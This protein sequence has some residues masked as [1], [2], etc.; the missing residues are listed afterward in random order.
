MLIITGA[1]ANCYIYS[2]VVNDYCAGLACSA[3]DVYHGMYKTICCSPSMCTYAS[4]LISSY[5]CIQNQDLDVNWAAGLSRV[6]T[7][8]LTFLASFSWGLVLCQLKRPARLQF[9]TFIHVVTSVNETSLEFKSV[10]CV[11]NL[12]FC[13]VLYR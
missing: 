9:R 5:T 13:Y 6:Q 8:C 12:S 10:F 11:Q 2:C 1:P 3:V 7:M 4:L